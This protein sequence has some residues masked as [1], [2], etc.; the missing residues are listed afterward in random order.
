MKEL[1]SNTKMK[2]LERIR[3]NFIRFTVV[4]SA[5]LLTL[6]LVG[7]SFASADQ[8]TQQIQSLQTQNDQDQQTISSL[9]SQA[10]TYQGEISLLQSQIDSLQAQISATQSNI[11]TVQA[12]ISANQAKLVQ[13]KQTLDEIIKT[14]YEDGHMTTLEMLAT[15]KNISEFV[16]KEEYQNIV[17]T[18]IQTTLASINQTKQP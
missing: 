14:M 3:I 15:S 5:V 4:I 1:T 11:D 2:K 16:T 13:E 9:Q 6:G 10:S 7:P 18:Q 8:F 17:Q 12:Q